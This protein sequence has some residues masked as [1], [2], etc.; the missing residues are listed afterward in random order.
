MKTVKLEIE[1]SDFRL[2]NRLAQRNFRTPELELK[3]LVFNEVL[4]EEEEGEGNM[5]T[6]TQETANATCH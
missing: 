5:K 2:L 3:R 1:R 6:T 4:K